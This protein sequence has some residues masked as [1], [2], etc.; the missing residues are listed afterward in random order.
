M[1][2]KRARVEGKQSLMEIWIQRKGTLARIETFFDFGFGRFLTLCHADLVGEVLEITG[3]GEFRIHGFFG[4][5]LGDFGCLVG[6]LLLILVGTI[7]GG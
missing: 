4:I 3:E 7:F 2:E 6:S 1:E 5:G